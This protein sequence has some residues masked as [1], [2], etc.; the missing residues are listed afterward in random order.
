ML[1]LVDTHLHPRNL[2]TA[3]LVLS[4]AGVLERRWSA[5]LWFACA[6][7]MHPTMALAGGWHLVFQLWPGKAPRVAPASVLSLPLLQGAGSSAGSGAWRE[8]L[9][10]RWFLFPLR[11]PWFAWMG[12][13]VPL[14]LL[15]WWSRLRD[16]QATAALRRV[17]ARLLWSGGLGTLGGVLITVTPGLERLVPSEPMRVLH[18]LTLLVVL[19]GGG[20]LGQHVLKTKAWRWAALFLPLCAVMFYSQRQLHRAGPHIDWPGGAP[21]NAWAQAFQWI[22]QNTPRDARFALDPRHM[23]LPG[24]GA[25]SFSALAER[26]RMMDYSKDRGVAATWPE[27]APEWRKQMR[28]LRGWENFRREDFLRLK[29]QYGV[30]WVVLERHSSAQLD[31]PY[32]NDAV[33]V[34]RME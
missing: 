23:E 22:R 11:W 14:A 3:C 17:S 28:D 27:L 16:D 13:V 26:S 20:L 8:V 24:E 34:C 15:A 10:T 9:E 1:E 19:L 33:K 31:C 6:A 21:A 2:A 29:R 25:Y 4:L 7:L 18:L 5:P 12:V 30:T 32:A